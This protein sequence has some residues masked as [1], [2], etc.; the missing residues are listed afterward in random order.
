[1]SELIVHAL[2]HGQSLCSFSTLRPIDWPEGHR[3]LGITDPYFRTYLV[4]C[5]GCKLPLEKLFPPPKL[6]DY[7]SSPRSDGTDSWTDGVYVKD[8][9]DGSIQ[10]ENLLGKIDVG[11][12]P[13]QVVLEEK[14]SELAKEHRRRVRKRL[15]IPEPN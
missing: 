5:L 3:W 9:G 14:L 1:M 15:N 6:G 10:I 11:Y 8:N 13:G 7:V 2:H 12:W 4:T